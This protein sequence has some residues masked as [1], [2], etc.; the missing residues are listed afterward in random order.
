MYKPESLRNQHV[1]R[2]G[3]G[4]LGTLRVLTAEDKKENAVKKE[5]L[6]KGVRQRLLRFHFE[7]EQE[8]QFKIESQTQSFARSYVDNENDEE[9]KGLKVARTR[10][11]LPFGMNIRKAAYK[12][13]IGNGFPALQRY[14]TF[15]ER[16]HGGN[17]LGDLDEYLD[18]ISD[19][20]VSQSS[21]ESVS[22]LDL[23]IDVDLLD[24]GAAQ[25]AQAKKVAEK[26]ERKLKK[27][28]SKSKMSSRLKMPKQSVSGPVNHTV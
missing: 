12:A 18:E 10:E 26:E 21:S 19:N 3:F 25:A 22:D 24:P 2:P 14:A 13:A 23:D 9:E 20:S 8:Q 6:V 27:T 17:D 5:I 15:K 11:S 4:P 16:K 1:S 28:E 7:N